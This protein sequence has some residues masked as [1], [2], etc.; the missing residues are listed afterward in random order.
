MKLSGI[1]VIQ[2]STVHMIQ[3]TGH[4]QAL[5]SLGRLLVLLAPYAC[6]AVGHVDV[7]LRAGHT[8]FKTHASRVHVSGQTYLLTVSVSTA[9]VQL[10][11]PGRSN[12]NVLHPAAQLI[13][14][15]DGI[16]WACSTTGHSAPR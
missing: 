2:P 11:N 1:L 16:C 13:E 10:S 8:P 14:M 9:G 5:P 3:S 6:V 12:D 4:R 15:R 7:E